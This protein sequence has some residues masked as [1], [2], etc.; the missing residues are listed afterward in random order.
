MLTSTLYAM[1]DVSPEPIH[2]HLLAISRDLLVLANSRDL[3]RGRTA[4]VKHMSQEL[5]C[6]SPSQFDTDD[7]LA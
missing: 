1:H 6:Q 7:P 3:G 4:L 2:R 5:L